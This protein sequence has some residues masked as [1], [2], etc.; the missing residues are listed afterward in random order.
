M[1]CSCVMAYHSAT[2]GNPAA[3]DNMD[4]P[5]GNCGNLRKPDTGKIITATSDTHVMRLLWFSTWE[6][7]AGEKMLK[8]RCEEVK[9]SLAFREACIMRKNSCPVME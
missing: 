8:V 6:Q 5:K 2:N 3:C 1:Y 4:Q 9:C 7:H